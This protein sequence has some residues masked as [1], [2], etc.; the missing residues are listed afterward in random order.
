MIRRQLIN[1]QNRSVDVRV[2]FGAFNELSRILSSAVGRP[3]RAL[4]VSDAET[5]ARYGENVERA[6]ADA[7]FAVASLNL[8]ELDRI[9]T[10]S[11]AD[12]L[13]GAL[14]HAD[15]TCDDL[16]VGLG[17]R[18]LCSLVGW[19]AN[20]WCGR[21][22]C[23]LLPTTFDAMICSATTMEPLA[24]SGSRGF[25]SIS[26]RPE[27]GTVV[28]DLDIVTSAAPLELKA[29]YVFLV[30]TIL[31]TSRSR[32]N[33]FSESVADILEGQEVAL[34][35]ALQWCQTARKDVLTATNPSARMA[36][37]F[38]KAGMHA[39][40]SALGGRAAGI[41]TWQLLSE[42]MRFEARLAHDACDLDID[43]VFELDDCLEDLGVEELAFELEPQTFIEAFRAEQ[44]RRSNRTML[45][46]PAAIG[47]IRL[48][49]VDDDVLERHARAYLAS[50]AELAV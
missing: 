22:E 49:P 24:P 39:L 36:L 37:D 28:C 19:C 30:G 18:T 7:G 5:R 34:V 12:I 40:A 43:D 25:A 47:A 42:G 15:I 38:G 26:M 32:W 3:K 13:F 4:L 2:G 6:L 23:V 27:P 20:M 14:A 48:T 33:Q 31:T 35:N 44:F 45:P 9:A 50:R 41:P 29:G 8:D 1:F 16:I 11:D 17:D 46:L 10:V 21:T